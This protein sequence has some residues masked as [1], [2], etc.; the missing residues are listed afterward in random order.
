MRVA[1]LNQNGLLD[2]IVDDMNVLIASNYSTAAPPSPVF[3]L[4]AITLLL[5]N[6]FRPH[7]VRERD[8]ECG[9]KT[10]KP[11]AK[12]FQSRHSEQGEIRVI[13]KLS[14]RL[15]SAKRERSRRLFEKLM[16]SHECIEG[17]NLYL[18]CLPFRWNIYSHDAR[19]PISLLRSSIKAKNSKNC[20][21]KSSCYY[22]LKH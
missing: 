6:W 3:Q 13:C 19:H 10:K 2:F 18:F 7:R 1:L 9:G 4:P 21:M 15:A 17:K 14:L 16:C 20:G 11:S 5:L 8:D 22:P 12:R